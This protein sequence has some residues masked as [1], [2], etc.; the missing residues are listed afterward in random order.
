M[1]T[2]STRVTSTPSRGGVHGLSCYTGCLAAYLAGDGIDVA[3]LLADSIRLAV[4]IDLPDGALAF[5]HHRL[6]LNRLPDGTELAYATEAS[7]EATA[8]ITE[9]LAVNGRVIVVVDNAELPWS[10]S[11]GCGP[12]APHWLLIDDRRGDKWHVVD[13]FSGLLASGEQEPFTGWLATRSLLEAMSVTHTWTPEQRCRNELA[14]GYPVR[15]PAGPGLTWLRRSPRSGDSALPGRWLLSYA[16]T[17]PF[18]GTYFGERLAQCALVS[19]DVWAVA[20]H[21]V[22]RHHWLAG[23]G[24]SERHLALAGAWS[25][26]PQALRFA[27]ESAARGRPRAGLLRTTL[28]N[29]LALEAS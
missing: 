22:F 15:V 26:L 1:I 4:R 2:D 17:L 27:V 24:D 12:S 13:P 28:D 3:A 23:Q 18:L 5:S 21:H 19:D 16:E 29:L 8:A 10:P 20:Q 6:A 14:F 11:Y 9:E 25:G 7:A